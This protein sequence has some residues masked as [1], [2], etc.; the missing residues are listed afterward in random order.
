MEH[1]RITKEDKTAGV[2]TTCDYVLLG[3]YE[4]LQA[5]LKAKDEKLAKLQEAT[6][7]CVIIIRASAQVNTNLLADKLEQ[8]LKGESDG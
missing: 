4:K 6:S 5:E 7:I 1:M 3:D 2:N 8:A